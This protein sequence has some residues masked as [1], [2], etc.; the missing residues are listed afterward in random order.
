MFEERNFNFES[1][2]FDAWEDVNCPHNE[3]REKDVLGKFK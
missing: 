1:M 3:M 2:R